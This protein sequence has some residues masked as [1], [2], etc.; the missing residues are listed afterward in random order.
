MKENKSGGKIKLKAKQLKKEGSRIELRLGR[1]PK[2]D[3][4]KILYLLENHLILQ[5]FG[6]GDFSRGRVRRLI[7]YPS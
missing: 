1:K 6:M 5:K 2:I 3:D 7:I 4:L